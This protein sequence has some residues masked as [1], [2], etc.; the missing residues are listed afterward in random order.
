MVDARAGEAEREDQRRVY[1]AQAFLEVGAV[2][3]G[4][5]MQP[6]GRD[7]RAG[8][9]GKR[10]EVADHGIGNQSGRDCHIRATIG[11]DKGGREGEGL[12]QVATGGLP[13][14]KQ[15]NRGG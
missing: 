1:G 10:I 13:P 5:V 9:C 11:C 8:R 7:R 12:R 3:F 4:D 15:G 6:V 14:T 2:L